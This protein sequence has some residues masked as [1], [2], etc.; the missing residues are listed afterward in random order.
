MD[1]FISVSSNA[2]YRGVTSPGKVAEGSRNREGRRVG[3]PMTQR[4]TTERMSA[5][6]WDC[7]SVQSAQAEKGPG[8]SGASS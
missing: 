7:K 5:L 2:R 3:F 6:S 8:C 4:K 1:S